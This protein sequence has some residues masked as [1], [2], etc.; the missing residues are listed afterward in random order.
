V[1][2][3]FFEEVNQAVQEEP[4]DAMDPETLGLLASISIE[5]AS[6]SRPTRG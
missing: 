4:G 3:S 6:P 1:D 5:K 2:Y